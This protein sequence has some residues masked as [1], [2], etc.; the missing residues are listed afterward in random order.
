M[1]GIRSLFGVV[2]LRH[3]RT[4]DEGWVALRRHLEHH[5]GVTG[6][7]WEFEMIR[8]I[9]FEEYNATVADAKH[10]YERF[11]DSSPLIDALRD[12]AIHGAPMEPAL[13]RD[14]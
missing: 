14:T 1:Q 13:M 10:L 2:N 8:R 5:I 12:L 3:G 9:L 11:P 4:R 6:Q 7:E